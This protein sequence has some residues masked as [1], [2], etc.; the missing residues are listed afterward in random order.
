MINSHQ[1]LE[2]RTVA[3]ADRALEALLAEGGPWYLYGPGLGEV[4]GRVRAAA[5]QATLP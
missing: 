5:R 2:W 1:A 4:E 3:P